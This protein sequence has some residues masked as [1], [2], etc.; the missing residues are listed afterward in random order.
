MTCPC[1]RPIIGQRRL[2]VYCRQAAPAPRRQAMC[3]CGR[4]MSPQAK[5]CPPCQRQRRRTMFE[6]RY[7]ERLFARIESR[8]R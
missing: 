3:S 4:P 8:M 5:H 6:T 1:G 7:I 2:C